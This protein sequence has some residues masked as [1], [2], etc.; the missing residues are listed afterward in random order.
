MFGQEMHSQE[1]RPGRQELHKIWSRS[2]RHRPQRQYKVSKVS[3]LRLLRCVGHAGA[4]KDWI[5]QKGVGWRNIAMTTTSIAER[6][7]EM[8]FVSVNAML[9]QQSAWLSV[10]R[11]A[12]PWSC[13]RFRFGS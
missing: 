11:K 8:L 7:V 13:W 6:A 1:E 3:E 5:S 2:E 4:L 10:S 12:C 9:R